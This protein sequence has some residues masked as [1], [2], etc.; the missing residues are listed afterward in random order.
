MLLLAIAARAT[1]HIAARHRR[2]RGA[3]GGAPGRLPDHD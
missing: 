1:R 3:R 2:G